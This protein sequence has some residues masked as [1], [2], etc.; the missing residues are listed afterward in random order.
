MIPLWLFT[1]GINVIYKVPGVT[2]PF[3][4][5]VTS[6]I[7]LVIPVGIGIIIQK[8]KPNWAR[9]ILKALRP[10]TVLFIILVFTLG[11]YANLYVFQLITPVV[12]VAGALVPY[13]GFLFG[14]VVAL[15]TRRSKADILTIAI[16]TGIQNTGVAIVL[17]QLSLPSPDSDIS[18]VAPIIGATFTP[19]PMV[20][21]MAIYAIKKRFCTN[22]HE[23]LDV[24]EFDNKEFHSNYDTEKT[25]NET[26]QVNIR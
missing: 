13:C 6:I 10:I 20:V 15:L 22:A 21:A 5:I 3:V 26:S 4:N 7:G 11:V 16:E 14:A 2:I 12:L 18:I 9:I 19:I 25:Y 24:Q 8:K 23:Q 17:L 1:L